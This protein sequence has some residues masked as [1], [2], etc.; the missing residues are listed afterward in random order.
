MNE[1][2]P[3]L[4]PDS[5][6]SGEDGSGFR[7]CPGYLHRGVTLGKPCLDA[8]AAPP[9]GQHIFNHHESVC[10][11]RRSHADYGFL[12][13]KHKV[14]ARWIWLPRVFLSRVHVHPFSRSV[15]QWVMSGALV[16][17]ST[18]LLAVR[19]SREGPLSSYWSCCYEGG[20]FL[21]EEW[22]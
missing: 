21:K 3:L 22:S 20:N 6:R 1:M 12:S 5:P 13:L 7:S 8:L 17:T 18:H 4:E 15:L 10:F 16:L 11:S 19:N 14:S 2:G 9:C